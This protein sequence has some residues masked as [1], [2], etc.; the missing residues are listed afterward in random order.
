VVPSSRP[1]TVVSDTT[2]Y[3]PTEIVEQNGIRLVSLYVNWEDGSERES[4]MASFD[5]FYERLRS[6]EKL[7]TTSQPSIGDFLEV[8]EPLIEQGRDVV[9]IHISGGISGTVDSAR[10]ARDRLSEQGAEG[11]VTVLDS[12]T[13]CGGLGLVA[14][15]A[16]Q[17]ARA[18]GNPDEVVERANEARD[19]L[20]M[21]FAVDTLEYLRRGGRIG[22]ASAWLGT[23]LKI[24]PILTL[25][26]EITPI[27]RVR[28]SARALER[29]ADYAEQRKADGADGWVVQHIQAPEEAE[30]LVKR[31]EEVMGR[32]PLF[33]SE[34][35]PVIGAHAGPGLLGVGGVPARI[36]EPAAISGHA[37]AG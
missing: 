24:K 22:A 12:K 2:A 35:G 20:K 25:E 4:D 31:A 17:A 37:R 6:A 9:S 15:A 14:L 36:V 33:V 10:Q 34:V 11:R 23:A 28:T 1:V 5:A 21:W 13:A 27:E 7:P 30:K 32:P 26:D 19:L 16:A 8:Y 3:L 18:E 29:L